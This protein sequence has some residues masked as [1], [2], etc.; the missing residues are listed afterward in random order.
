MAL[1][2]YRHGRTERYAC[3]ASEWFDDLH[4]HGFRFRRN[5]HVPDVR[6]RFGPVR[7]TLANPVHWVRPRHVRQRDVL[8]RPLVLRRG[9]F[10]PRALL[11]R[12]CF[13]LPSLDA[14]R[15][16]SSKVEEDWWSG[17]LASHV[18]EQQSGISRR[19]FRD[20][21]ES[22]CHEQYVSTERFDGREGLELGR[23]PTYYHQQRL[24]AAARPN[25]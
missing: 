24:I 19:A 3:S 20:Y 6:E 15:R 14:R 22:S 9:R 7:R 10:V 2:R 16:A 1:R 17:C 21:R 13:H 25:S 12:R 18:L 11:Q 5:A 23:V 4:A 8:A